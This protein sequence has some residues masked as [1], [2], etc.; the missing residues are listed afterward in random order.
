VS[1][2]VTPERLGAVILVQQLP[3]AGSRVFC[4]DRLE[5]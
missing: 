5:A 3:R 1:S 2:R 4:D